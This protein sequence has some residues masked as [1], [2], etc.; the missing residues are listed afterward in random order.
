[1]IYPFPVIH[2]LF[3]ILKTSK[4]FEK[5]EPKLKKLLDQ[6]FESLQTAIDTAQI[7]RIEIEL[8]SGED[9]D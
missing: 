9:E 7:P 4:Q 5:I 8:D 6:Q 1:M 3:I 2:V